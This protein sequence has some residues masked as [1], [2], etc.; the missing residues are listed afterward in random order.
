[1]APLDHAWLAAWLCMR[2]EG[3]EH[4]APDFRDVLRRKA[5]PD[6]RLGLGE[7][8]LCVECASHPKRGTVD[9]LFEYAAQ[10]EVIL[11]EVRGGASPYVTP[12]LRLEV[13]LSLEFVRQS[14]PSFEFHLY[15]IAPDARSKE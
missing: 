7:G 3:R 15:R 2:R 13:I 10:V 11:A 9:D 1:M 4:V 8:S 14:P 5:W 12:G 6:A